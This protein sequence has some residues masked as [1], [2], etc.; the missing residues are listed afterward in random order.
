MKPQKHSVFPTALVGC[1]AVGTLAA[2]FA[3]APLLAQNMQIGNSRNVAT[4][5][6]AQAGQGKDACAKTCASCHATNLGG[7]EFASSLR[8]ATFTLN[9]GG[10]NAAPLF[11]FIATKMPPASPGS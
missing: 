9:W 4:F 11:I 7:S 8:G 3:P 1:I 2:M 6:A 5:T 10:Q